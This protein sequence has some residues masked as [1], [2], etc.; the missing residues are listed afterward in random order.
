MSNRE[1]M[2]HRMT[3]VFSIAILALGFA[4]V[5]RTLVAGG[6]PVS[7]GLVIGLLLIALGVARGYLAVRSLH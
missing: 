1:R 7:L 2:Y 5:V 3:L 6:G 4:T